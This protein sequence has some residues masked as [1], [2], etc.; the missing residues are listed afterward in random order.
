MYE[1]NVIEEEFHVLFLPY[2]LFI[3]NGQ[4]SGSLFLV[5]KGI[6]ESFRV[7]YIIDYFSLMYKFCS[8]QL[9]IQN[10]VETSSNSTVTNSL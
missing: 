7:L 3:P 9:T 1:I 10:D 6:V 8:Y 2:E 4:V 5:H